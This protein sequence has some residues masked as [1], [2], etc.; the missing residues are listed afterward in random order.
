M[1][2]LKAGE[3]AHGLIKTCSS[4]YHS[5]L[6]LV[7]T[8]PVGL[9]SQ[10]FWGLI[11][12][13]LVLKLGC[14]MW[15]TNAW[16]LGEKLWVLSSLP[17]VGHC[18]MC[19]IYGELVLAF[20]THF[21]AVFPLVCPVWKGHSANFQSFFFPEEIILYVDVDSGVSIGGGEFGILLY[22]YLEAEL[23]F[24][25]IFKQWFSIET[26]TYLSIHLWIDTWVVS[27]S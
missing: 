27:I 3:S 4:V 22:C 18:I 2:G 19:G 6:S 10:M 20:P 24:P 12:Q 17:I 14:L 26:T 11:F 15:G 16:L 23:T 13:V 1:L 8:S 9:Q 21:D 5:P 7:G 25:F